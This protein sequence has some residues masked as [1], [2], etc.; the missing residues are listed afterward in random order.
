MTHSLPEQLDNAI[1]Q[2]M[3]VDVSH[4]KTENLTSI[5]VLGM[6]GS[7]VS[8]DIVSTVLAPSCAIPVIV[9]KNY[10]LPAF[11]NETTLVIAP[12]YSGTTEETLTAV[13][14]AR[15]RGSQLIAVCS[16]G[17]LAKIAADWPMNVVRYS[18]PDG[19]Q[20]RAGMGALCGPLFVALDKLGLLEDGI[21]QIESAYTQILKRRDEC[22]DP[23]GDHIASRLV[24][25]ISTTIP[26]IYGAGALG[27][28]AANRFKS[29]V[30][31]NAKAPAYS[32]Y[33]PELCHNEIVGYG[34]NGDVTRQIL[35]LVE[36]RHSFEHPQNQR[37]FDITRELIR[38]TVH[39]II[40]V[41]AQGETRLA[42]LFDLTY[43]GSLAS[44]YMALASDVDPGPVDVIWQLKNA[45]ADD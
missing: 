4:I 19:L 37:R 26:V 11:V 34:Q 28:V 31:E 43:I 33:Y 10:E 8:G 45:L 30:N 2:A 35:T 22:V 15:I 21:K 18:A 17:E 16:G 14:E 27:A 39:D 5:I 20:P 24:S 36:L 44:V 6:G 9:C 12:S 3:S 42:Q 41:R 13:K 25:T 38:E 29:D 40:E 7:G 32:H 1:N 23:A